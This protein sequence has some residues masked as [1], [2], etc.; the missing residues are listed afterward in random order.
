MSVPLTK[1]KKKRANWGKGG[2][3]LRLINSV[4]DWDN[5]TDDDMDRNN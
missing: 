2:N 3:I 1:V 4:H 5:K